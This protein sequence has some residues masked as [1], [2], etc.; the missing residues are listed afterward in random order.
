MGQPVFASGQKMGSCRVFFGSDRVGSENSL[1][2][3]AMST[4]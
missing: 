4:C 2:R 3:F 1:T